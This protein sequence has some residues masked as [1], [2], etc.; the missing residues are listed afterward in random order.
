VT[1]VVV[2][3]RSADHLSNCL[4]A[5]MAASVDHVVEVIVV[6]NDSPDDTASGVLLSGVEARVVRTGGNH[7]FAAAANLGAGTGEGEYV[8][9]VN[10]DARPRPGSVDLL[11]DAA[12]RR[13]GHLLYSGRVVTPSGEV[14]RGCCLPLPSL[15]EYVC[16]ATGLSTVFR[17]HRLLDPASLG[18]WNRDSECVVPAV[19]GAF[20]LARRSGFLA[21]GGFDPG[22]FMYSEDADLSARA[23]ALG[24]PPLLVSTAE[25][26]HDGG[27]SSTTGMKTRMVLRGKATYVRRHW[28]PV[29]RAA[30][31]VLLQ[32]GVGV[33]AL[34][35]ALLGGRAV[36]WHEAWK[37]REEWVAGW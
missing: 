10:P 31:L 25:A 28:S 26:E 12:R 30:G 29:R 24:R 11:V 2:A 5:I 1:A 8:V 13:P 19:S 18:G 22:Y 37:H 27:G 7:G 9:F 4:P 23:H 15:W 36:H 17:G 21:E 20:L 3:Y 35:G 32:L 16:F 6:D 33:R 34:A 14:D